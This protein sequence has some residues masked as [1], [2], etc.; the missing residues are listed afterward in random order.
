MILFIY[1]FYITCKKLTLKTPPDPNI[2]DHVFIFFFYPLNANWIEDLNCYL[3]VKL[4][5]IISNDQK[6]KY[7]L[8][9]SQTTI[10]M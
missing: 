4:F 3:K 5:F 6:E 9:A 7:R 1:L 10:E 8:P 2:V